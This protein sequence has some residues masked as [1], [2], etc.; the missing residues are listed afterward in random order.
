MAITDAPH[1]MFAKYLPNFK[2]SLSILDTQLSQGPLFEIAFN[3]GGYVLWFYDN[4][5]EW[6]DLFQ[7]VVNTGTACIRGWI[8][9]SPEPEKIVGGQ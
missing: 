8:S 2:L 6:M 9:S 3:F 5:N 4:M 1:Q 7:L